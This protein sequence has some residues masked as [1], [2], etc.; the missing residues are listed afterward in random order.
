MQWAGCQL[1]NGSLL[2]LGLLCTF[3]LHLGFVIVDSPVSGLFK[4]ATF[5]A[6]RKLM[7]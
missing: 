5:I 7:S 6:Q 4:T 3:I 2:V 1:P